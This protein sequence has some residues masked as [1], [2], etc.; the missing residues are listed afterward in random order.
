[1]HAF[2]PVSPPDLR[3]SL[4]VAHPVLR[5]PNFS[6]TIVL[7]SA[8]SPGDGAP[9]R[10]HQPSPPPPPP[11]PLGRTLGDLKDEFRGT[12]IGDVP[13]F[14]GGPVATNE[15]LLTAW[16]W[17]VLGGTF[18]L[19][20]GISAEALSDLVR[21]EPTMEAR[22]FLGYS[23]WGEGQV[24]GELAEDAWVGC[25]AR[26][27]LSGGRNR[28]RSGAKVLRAEKPELTFLAGRP[29]G[30]HS[31]LRTAG[32]GRASGP[33]GRWAYFSSSARSSSG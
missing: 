17:D 13:V 18:R 30:S 2:D 3:G 26:P 21:D 16:D 10:D 5:D 8:H 23:G 33:V 4:L 31:Q 28:A 19:H 9:R 32:A 27:G 22:A 14:L 29:G 24:E 6:R 25:A 7:I 11:P 1:M 12:T 15:V 20:F